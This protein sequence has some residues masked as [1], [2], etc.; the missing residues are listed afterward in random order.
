MLRI[1]YVPGTVLGLGNLTVNEAKNDIPPSELTSYLVGD[2]A[3]KRKTNKY[4]IQCLVIKK[5]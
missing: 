4:A 5:T 3:I 2:N 1:Y